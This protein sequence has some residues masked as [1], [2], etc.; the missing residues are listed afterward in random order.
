M[1][2]NRWVTMSFRY[3]IRWAVI[4]ALVALA[5]CPEALPHCVASGFLAGVAI[6]TIW[7]ISRIQ[8]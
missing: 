5:F 3:G 7:E 6:A 4:M 8:Y 2:F 1:N